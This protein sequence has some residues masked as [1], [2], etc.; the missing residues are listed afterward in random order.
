LPVFSATSQTPLTL[1][2][3]SVADSDVDYVT[4]ATASAV[5]LLRTGT[6]FPRWQ[7]FPSPGLQ[8]TDALPAFDTLGKFRLSVP[9][10]SIQGNN[11]LVYLL[12]VT[13]GLWAQDTGVH[14]T[15][16]DV[17][18]IILDA[19][20][21]SPIDSSRFGYLISGSNVSGTN[22]GIVTVSGGTKFSVK[23]CHFRCRPQT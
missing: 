19:A 17:K 3:A 18:A 13:T 6:H 11:Y 9:T 15:T 5:W 14:V 23:V 1:R 12:D 2:A 22:P 16:T 10:Y 21:A 7:Q 8:V 20:F 4:V